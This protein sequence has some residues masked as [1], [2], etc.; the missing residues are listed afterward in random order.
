MAQRI[1][2]L[3]EIERSI[4]GQTAERRRTVRQQLSTPLVADL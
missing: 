2:A 4:N 3:F 1:D